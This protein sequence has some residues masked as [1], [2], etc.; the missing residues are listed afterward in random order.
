MFNITESNK[1]LP[2]IHPVLQLQGNNASKTFIIQAG[3]YES[4]DVADIIQNESDGNVKNKSDKY[5]MKCQVNIG[6]S[7]NFVV[8]RSITSLLEFK[9]KTIE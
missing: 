2:Y 9:N 8:C 1:Q 5:T 7:I 4:F 3:A 6:G